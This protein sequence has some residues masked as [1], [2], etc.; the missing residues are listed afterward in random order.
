MDKNELKEKVVDYASKVFFYFI[1]RVNC[2]MDAEDLSQTVLLEVIQ[3]I[4]NGARIDNLDYYIWGVCKNQYNM[5]LRR[6][7]KD[8]NKIEYGEDIVYIDNTMSMLD[9]MIEDEKIRKISNAIKLLSKDYAE[10]LY[11]YYVEDKTLTSIAKEINVPLGTIKWRLSEIR[12]KLKEYLDMERLNDKKAYIPK[13]FASIASYDNKLPFDPHDIVKP[14]FIKNLL[15][16]IFDNPCTLEDLSIE[17]GMAKPYVEDVVNILLGVK[18]IIKEKNKYKANIAFL[19]KETVQKVRTDLRKYYDEYVLEVINFAKENIE[20]YRNRL[21]DKNINDKL[22]MWSLLMTIRSFTKE[23]KQIFTKKYSNGSLSF[24]MY[25]I[26]QMYDESDFYISQNGFGSKHNYKLYGY[27]YP[28]GNAEYDKMPKI[29]KRIKYSN[30]CKGF[31][32]N[33][34]FFSKVAF[35]EVKYSELSENIKKEVDS[36]LINLNYMKVENDVLKIVVPMMN[37]KEFYEFKWQ[38]LD[39]EKLTKSYDNLYSRAK[40]L[41]IKEIPDY[42]KE[43]A[44]FLVSSVLSNIRTSILTKAYEEDLLDFDEEHDYFTYNMLLVKC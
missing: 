40:Q 35:E 33:A 20:N 38:I 43:E 18:Y 13:T 44:T 15:Y 27:A 14:L 34:S 5:Y 10:I 22:L 1:K 12:K 16:H 26:N 8:K 25:E 29:H 41:I 2:K 37:E 7:I 30:A 19:D 21:I 6:I 23:E 3:N 32:E 42:L 39:N 17:M 24:C 36:S 11:A 28:A 9:K 4:N 31:S